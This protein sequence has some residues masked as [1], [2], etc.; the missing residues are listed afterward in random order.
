M[1]SEAEAVTGS[2][3]KER[4]SHP[5]PP[6]TETL[7]WPRPPFPRGNSEGNGVDKAGEPDWYPQ[8]P[9]NQALTRERC[10]QQPPLPPH[11]YTHTPSSWKFWTN[12]QSPITPFHDFYG[13]YKCPG[14]KERF[15]FS[16]QKKRPFLYLISPPTPHP[17]NSTSRFCPRKPGREGKG[18]G[19]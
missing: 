3:P 18:S 2:V 5:P 19:F 13:L 12:L 11:P 17:C 15:F 6:P 16:F 8:M 14:P 7:T 1:G 4:P 10:H 9:G